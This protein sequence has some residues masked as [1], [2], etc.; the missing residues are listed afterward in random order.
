M[1]N[2]RCVRW[3]VT[4]ISVAIGVLLAIL[5]TAFAP[6]AEACEEVRQD[7]LRLHILANSD[8]DEDQALKLKVRDAVLAAQADLFGAASSKEDAIEI[9]TRELE[10]IRTVAQKTVWQEGYSYPV[11]VRLENIYFATKEYEEFT[12]PAGRYD[13]VRIEIGEQAG[14]NWFCVLF[15]P[16]CVPAAVD[17]DDTTQYTEEE[18]QVLTSPYRIKFAAI[19]LFEY[20]KE[21]VK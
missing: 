9:A 21:S 6:F 3:K 13:A 19:E 11:R 4:E 2:H 15:P 7:T 1:K 5:I 20:L 18:Q 17:A 16:L 8:S 12:L 10:N 14:H